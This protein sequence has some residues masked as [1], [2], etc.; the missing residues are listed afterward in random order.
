MRVVLISPPGSSILS[1]INVEH[2]DLPSNIDSPREDQVHGNEN[3][4]S[5]QEVSNLLRKPE[6]VDHVV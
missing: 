3:I 5:H 2:S 4:S 6:F 1:P